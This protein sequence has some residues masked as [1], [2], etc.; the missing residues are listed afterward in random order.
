[1]ALIFYRFYRNYTKGIKFA[2][3]K[4]YHGNLRISRKIS[5]MLIEQIRS[6]SHQ[7]HT[8]LEQTLLPYINNIKTAGDYALLLK[9][10]YGYIMPV[11]EKVFTHIN[12][13]L[14]P[15][16]HKRRTAALIKED[17]E[18]LGQLETSTVCGD[19]PSIDSHHAALGALYVLEGS[20]LG[21]K[22]IAKI[23]A[24]NTGSTAALKFFQGYGEKTGSMWKNF[25]TYLHQHNNP[26]YNGIIVESARETFSLFDKWLKEKLDTNDGKQS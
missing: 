10:F 24:E 16:I 14:V 22:I 1:M 4:F 7:E 13:E 15:D 6:A 2:F 23:I 20:T 17:L 11:Q 21:G 26:A 3:R 9:S 18:E 8:R 19:L 12:K 25:L 5:L